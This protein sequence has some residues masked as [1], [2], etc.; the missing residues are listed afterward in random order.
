VKIISLDRNKLLEDLRDS[1]QRLQLEHPEVLEVR[2]FGSLA[3]GDYTGTSDV[4]LLV[5]LQR[6]E[7]MDPVRRVMTFLP[8]F[9]LPCSVDLIVYT[10]AELERGL[11]GN[12]FLQQAW[13]E[14]QLLS[15]G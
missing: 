8:Y 13:A 11:P 1:V 10:R 2:L 3:R 6:A 5:V 14:S 4:D 12:A 15:P 9:D 7:D